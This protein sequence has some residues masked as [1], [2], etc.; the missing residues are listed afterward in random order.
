[1]P[2]QTNAL[3]ESA[4]GSLSDRDG[5]ALT[6]RRLQR[7]ILRYGTGWSFVDVM[8]VVSDERHSISTQ[9]DERAPAWVLVSYET[10]R[11]L[12]VILFLVGLFAIYGHMVRQHDEG[13][14]LSLLKSDC[15]LLNYLVEHFC[16]RLGLLISHTAS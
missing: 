10:L 4:E 9:G 7:A 3:R 6:V 8:S 11:L 15:S 13:A 2:E 16:Q 12:G 14:G 5:T 1:M